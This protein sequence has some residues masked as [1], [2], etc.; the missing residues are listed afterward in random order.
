MMKLR[1]L[2]LLFCGIFSTA[3]QAQIDRSTMPESGELPEI[4]L[5]EPDR[6][7]FNNG[8]ELLVVEDHKLP[9]VN[10]RLVIDN[11]PIIEDKPGTASLLSS[12]LGTGTENMSKDEFNEEV[13]FLG[14]NVNLSAQSAYASSLKRYFERILELMA[15]GALNPKFTEENFKAEKDKLIEGI[16]TNQKSASAIASRV[17]R[18]LAYG[19]D[20]PFGQ[21]TT[22]ESVEDITLDDVKNMYRNY[23][24][25]KNAYMVVVGDIKS[26]KAKKLVK[27]NFKKWKEEVPP[28]E[29]LPEPKNVQFTQ[30]NLVDMPNAVQSEIYV[31]NTV[32][33]QMSDDDYF[34]ALVANRIL[35]GGGTLGSYLNMNLR[36]DKGYTYGAGS[37]IGAS[38]YASRFYATASVRNAV[39]DSAVVEFL[40]EIDHIRDSIVKPKK[41]EDVKSKFAGSFVM[42]LED[43]STIAR[44]ALNKETNDLPDDFYKNY[45]KKINAVTAEDVQRVAKK[46]IKPGNLRIVI[47]GKG[48]EVAAPL[49]KMTYNEKNVPVMYFNKEGEKVDK[50]VFSKEIPEGVTLK[51][52]YDQYIEAIGGREAVEKVNSV[53][54]KGKAKVQGMSIDMTIKRTQGGKSLMEMSMGGNVMNKTVFDGESGYTMA[55]GQK[56]EMSDEQ[57]EEQ[58]ENAGLFPELEVDKSHELV[59]IVPVDGEDAY[60][61]KTGEDSKAYYSVESGLKIMDET[62]VKQGGKEVTNKG[63]YQEYQE[64]NGIKMPKKT[65]REYGPQTVKI[66][67][68]EIKF[69]E[70]VSASDFE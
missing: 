24:V 34:P 42:N 55:R 57:I 36:E 63:K 17:S 14:A 15:D 41:L 39:T 35:G 53:M 2:A 7:S 43:K 40:K 61:V 32:D 12:M 9:Q 60:V 11:K 4:N 29:T 56:M 68:Q 67:I 50:P 10:A 54:M 44:Y 25:P 46:Y 18:A 49:E 66:E 8:L 48:S 30:V 45:L 31:Q 47:A 51:T 28:S 38:Q 6:Y 1:I 23:F 3:L 5:G 19:K 65:V 64:V 59:S 20:H 33:L 58:K 22:V 62:T 52:V 16:K 21:V 27:R 69:D 26:K 13:D 37:N 70:G